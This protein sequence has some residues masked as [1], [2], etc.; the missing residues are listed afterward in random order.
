MIQKFYELVERLV[1]ARRK[2]A[3]I[4]SIDIFYHFDP[5]LDSAGRIRVSL[6]VSGKDFTDYYSVGKVA[7]KEK[8]E[9]LVKCLAVI[10]RVNGVQWG[11]RDEFFSQH[12][13]LTSTI[14][15]EKDSETYTITMWLPQGNQPILGINSA[16]YQKSRYTNGMKH[17][18][19][20][21]YSLYG[22]RQVRLVDLSCLHSVGQLYTTAIQYVQRN[23]YYMIDRSEPL[24]AD[25]GITGDEK[26]VYAFLSLPDVEKIRLFASLIAKIDGPEGFGGT[27]AFAVSDTSMYST[28]YNKQ[29]NIYHGTSQIFPISLYRMLVDLFQLESRR[30]SY[31]VREASSLESSVQLVGPL[32]EKSITT[33]RA[34]FSSRKKSYWINDNESV[35]V[36]VPDTPSSDIIARDSDDNHYTVYDNIRGLIETNPYLKVGDSKILLVSPELAGVNAYYIDSVEIDV[37]RVQNRIYCDDCISKPRLTVASGG[38]KVT[39]ECHDAGGNHVEIVAT[40]PSGIVLLSDTGRGIVTLSPNVTEENYNAIWYTVVQ[41]LNAETTMS[42][43]VSSLSFSRDIYD[44]NG[45]YVEYRVIKNIGLVS[46]IVNAFFTA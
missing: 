30:R 15:F 16:G 40:A 31:I 32:Q 8:L 10:P 29:T 45:Q 14:E 2:T 33:Y 25:V 42:R 20:F 5:D 11:Q 41:A 1:A 39:L 27:F 19:G 3:S 38:M 44:S 7:G 43:G 21:C 18:I 24:T 6:I 36:I 13:L 12:P 22:T 34:L 9:R 28:R 35:V 23:G 4:E 46:S 26:A 17:S 37:G